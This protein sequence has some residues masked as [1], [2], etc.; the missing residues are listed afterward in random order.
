[1]RTIFNFLIWSSKF[2]SEAIPYAITYVSS[3]IQHTCLLFFTIIEPKFKIFMILLNIIW[4]TKQLISVKPCPFLLFQSH[5]Y[6]SCMH[7]IKFL[8]RCRDIWT[9]SILWETKNKMW[10]LEIV[11]SQSA[12]ITSHDQLNHGT[13]TWKKATTTN[14][15]AYS[16][17][18]KLTLRL[19]MHP[20]IVC[21][22]VAIAC[23]RKGSFTES[24]RPA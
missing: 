20:H 8:V 2:M 1:M 7:L 5:A 23:F 10:G 12:N 6:D 13:Y 18:H 19:C 24:A 22:C 17:M 3:F 16:S 9:Y 15:V 11:S 4:E 14:I 21:Q